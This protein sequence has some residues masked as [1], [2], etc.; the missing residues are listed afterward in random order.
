M[1]LQCPGGQWKQLSL[2][3][4][5]KQINVIWQLD[6]MKTNLVIIPGEIINVLQPTDISMNKPFK[7]YVNGY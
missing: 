5:M 3:D 2:P 1:W 4:A 7:L 6:L